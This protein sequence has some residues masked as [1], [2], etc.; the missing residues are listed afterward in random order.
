MFRV[1]GSCSTGK[2]RPIVLKLMSSWDHP[3]ALSCSSK[4]KAY[5]ECIYITADEPLETCRQNTL[6]RLKKQRAERDGKQTDVI[7]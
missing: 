6:F 3:T 4:L 7:K 1:G 2:T 5:P